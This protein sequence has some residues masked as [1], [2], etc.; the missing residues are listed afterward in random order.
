MKEEVDILHGVL[1][2][3]LKN[4]LTTEQRILV[5]KARREERSL[6]VYVIESA[7]ADEKFNKSYR[8]ALKDEIQN[9]KIAIEEYKEEIK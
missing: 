6:I 5:W 9:H 1:L 2:V 8:E 7:L 4:E 3:S